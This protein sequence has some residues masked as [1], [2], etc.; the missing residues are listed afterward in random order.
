MS[1]ERGCRHAIN[2]PIVEPS[3]VLLSPPYIKLG[4]MKQFVKT[5]NKGQCFYHIMSQ[6]PQ[7]SNNKL[8]EEIFY[9]PQ[10]QKL[11]KD[12]VFVIKMTLTEKKA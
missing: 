5:L 12:D 6:F 3:K 10:I 7:L 4:L 1:P 2:D 8:K 11:L 9:G